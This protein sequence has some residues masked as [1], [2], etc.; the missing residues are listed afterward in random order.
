MSDVATQQPPLAPSRRN[1]RAMR[2]AGLGFIYWLAFLLVLEPNNLLRA[3]GQ[4]GLSEEVTRILGAA[5]LGALATPLVL[6]LV[7]QYP[8]EGRR[9]WQN[10]L[11]LAL[12]GTGIAL[13]LIA[14]SCVLADLFLARELRPLGTALVEET[15][16]NGPLVAFCIA[17]LIALAH[18]RRFFRQTQ[19]AMEA[20]HRA[21]ASPPYLTKFAVKLRGQTAYLEASDVDWIETQGNYLALHAGKDVHLIRESLQRLDEQL[22]P[23]CFA[24]I[25][26][27]VIV[28]ID[29]IAMTEPLGAGDARIRLKDGAELRLSRGFRAR[30]SGLLDRGNIGET[31]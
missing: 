28:A 29:R 26:R 13:G 10:G 21:P 20:A 16:G 5:F 23:A 14:I 3:N 22:D 12:G 31:R 2:E 8:V 25:H 30:L 17:G 6:T 18:A 19:E 11:K 15:I 4:L 9:G 7:R 24:R 27:R 1:L